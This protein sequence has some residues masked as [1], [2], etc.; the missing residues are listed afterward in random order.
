MFGRVV[1]AAIL[2]ATSLSITP[3]FAKNPPPGA[4][5]APDVVWFVIG[6]KPANIRLEVD[7]P[8]LRNDVALNFHYSLDSYTPDDGFIVVKA[9][10]DKIYG[11]AAS[12]FMAGKTIFGTRYKPCNEVPKFMG[13]GGKVLYFTNVEYKSEGSAFSFPNSE[14]FA[15]AK[16]SQDIEAARAYLKTHYPGLA[17]SLEQ[18]PNEMLQVAHKCA[19]K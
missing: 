15:S 10:P 19:P 8:L 12:S 7:E 13:G 5:P 2:A 16:Y 11:I 6:I 3:A 17:D 9:K 18:G 4:S 1:L 14:F